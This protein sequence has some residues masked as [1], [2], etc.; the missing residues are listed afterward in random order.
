MPTSKIHALLIFCSL[1]M[2]SG[3]SSGRLSN[4]ILMPEIASANT[5]THLNLPILLG[6]SEGMLSKESPN[7]LNTLFVH[8]GLLLFNLD[9]DRSLAMEAGEF[10]R[11]R[12]YAGRIV[13]VRDRSAGPVLRHMLEDPGTQFVGIHY[14]TGGNP[15]YLRSSIEATREAGLTRQ[16]PLRYHAIMIDPSG[17]DEVET[18]V[19]IE[20]PEI[21]YLFI[22]LSSERSLLRP[23]IS[24]LSQ[25]LLDSGK[26]YVMH[27]EDFGEDWDHFGMLEAL[28]AF[29]QGSDSGGRKV[30]ILLEYLVT[31]AL[32]STERLARL[33]GPC[34]NV[35]NNRIA[36]DAH[37]RQ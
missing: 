14:S 11:D 18:V 34:G 13:E 7:R 29:K 37:Q 22:I 30:E 27:A 28:R 15:H 35:G 5:Q 33:P 26:V 3:C 4:K 6:C 24:G 25:K 9:W 36:A 20:A 32:G 16:T 2:I 8:P 1:V 17:I 12:T 31:V 23:G 19:D 21:G 10:L